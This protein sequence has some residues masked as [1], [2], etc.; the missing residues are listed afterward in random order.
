MFVGI[1]AAG[2]LLPWF[3]LPGYL[4]I[5][6]YNATL[7]G[8]LSTRIAAVAASVPFA[9]A[10]WYVETRRGFDLEERIG[11][12]LVPAALFFAIRMNVARHL[13]LVLLIPDKRG[14]RNM[15]VAFALALHALF[16][17]TVRLGSVLSI[18]IG[19]LALMLAADLS[20]IGWRT[21][22]RDLRHP[23]QMVARPSLPLLMC[24]FASDHRDQLIWIPMDA[25]R[26]TSG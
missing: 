13:L 19:L 11:W 16:P 12:G 5:Y 24:G 3:L 14:R 25:R 22:G 6:S 8:S 9:A 1:L 26:G 7:K 2:F 10:L 18:L 20:A 17:A 15:A 21:V 23:L 4:S